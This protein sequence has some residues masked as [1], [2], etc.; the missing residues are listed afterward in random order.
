MKT[1][2]YLQALAHIFADPILENTG[3]EGGRLISA[4]ALMLEFV[5]KLF[6]PQL[7]EERQQLQS[8]LQKLERC[9]YYLVLLE[10]D[11]KEKSSSACQTICQDIRALAS[12]DWMLIPGGWLNRTK[13]GHAMLYLLVPGPQLVVIT[14]GDGSQY[15]QKHPLPHTMQL[16][17]LIAQLSNKEQIISTGFLEAAIELLKTPADYYSAGMLY[18]VI[19]PVLGGKLEG[20]FNPLFAFDGQLAGTCFWQCVEKLLFYLYR[21]K[22]AVFHKM[23]HLWEKYLL[24]KVFHEL[25]GYI[26]GAV[27]LSDMELQNAPWETYFQ[28][29]R[30]AIRHFSLKQS[31][32]IIASP[33]IPEQQRLYFLLEQLDQYALQQLQRSHTLLLPDTALTRRLWLI[34]SFAAV[35]EGQTSQHQPELYACIPVKTYHRDNFIEIL[36]QYISLTARIDW[37]KHVSLNHAHF[38][39]EQFFIYLPLPHSEIWSIFLSRPFEVSEIET[40]VAQLSQLLEVYYRLQ[41]VL[42]AKPSPVYYARQLIAGFSAFCFID[43]LS[44]NISA[45]AFLQN[46]VPTVHHLLQEITLTTLAPTLVV[47]SPQLV[48]QLKH[49]LAYCDVIKLARPIFNLRFSA[50]YLSEWFIQCNENEQLADDDL[51][52]DCLFA[53]HKQDLFYDKYKHLPEVQRRVLGIIDAD[54]LFLPRLIHCWRNSGIYCRLLLSNFPTKDKLLPQKIW[55]ISP[56]A[57]QQSAK[58]VMKLQGFT[59]FKV[60]MWSCYQTHQVADAAVGWLCDSAAVS[61]LE[62]R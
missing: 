10:K 1:P 53:F 61:I 7:P 19:L 43:V 46:Y 57:Q 56:T 23:Q 4:I 51:L 36:S 8:L 15:H 9:K 47:N 44:K 25:Q 14:T 52:K 24:E 45:M 22:P 34:D 2:K 60:T 48:K 54:G 18:E 40:I 50:N 30:F 13:P 3:L 28:L 38:A 17:F 59:E 62:K 20:S 32:L 49:I 26:N 33:N 27:H 35:F 39:I 6:M 11:R 42:Y 29:I 16:H 58:I 5:E 41:S 55:H 21:Q 12:H 31:Q 37:D